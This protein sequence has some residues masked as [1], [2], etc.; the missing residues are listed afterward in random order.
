[1]GDI[2]LE[3]QVKL[4][5]VLQERVL[6]RV[7][8]REQIAVDVR[9]VAATHRDLESMITSGQFREDLYY[10]LKVIPIVLPPLRERREDIPELSQ[11]FLELHQRNMKKQGV[12]LPPEVVRLLE[13]RRWPGNI[14]ELRNEVERLVAFTPTGSPVDPSL[15]S[16]ES[17]R[18]PL[19]P[20][21]AG[22][23][24]F[25]E[26]GTI[27]DIMDRIEGHVVRHFMERHRWNQT[28]AASRLGVTRQALA[29]KLQKFGITVPRG[30]EEPD[31]EDA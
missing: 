28:S 2:P 8:G 22:T 1:V 18:A 9:V 25:D 7:G 24:S 12:T 6:E 23:L 16:D 31:P 5:R 29:K 15:L 20:G 13:T 30:T 27:H 4:L 17:E 14:R 19:P 10:R 21:H 26:A 3:T 11:R